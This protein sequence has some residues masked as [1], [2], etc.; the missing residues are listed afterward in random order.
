[1]TSIRDDLMA[2]PPGWYIAFGDMLCEELEEENVKSNLDLIILECKEKYGE[3]RIYYANGNEKIEDIVDKY[4][5]ISQHVCIKC[6]KPDV[7][8]LNFSWV[9]PMCKECYEKYINDTRTYEKV[10]CLD[11]GLKIKDHYTVRIPDGDKWV[12]K[13][14]DISETV[15]KIRKRWLDANNL[16]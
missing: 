7:F 2:M 1:M 3:L 9:E 10:V 15:E 5:A 4:A 8:I 13:K 12:T 11:A 14:I 6:G 16:S